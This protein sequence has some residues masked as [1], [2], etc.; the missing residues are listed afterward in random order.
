[1]YRQRGE[2]V[3]RMKGHCAKVGLSVFDFLSWYDTPPPT[4]PPGLLGRGGLASLTSRLSRV[5]LLIFIVIL[6]YGESLCSSHLP[7][8]LCLMGMR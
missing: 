3:S 6:G 2:G 5:H 4:P 8:G 1:M 7:E